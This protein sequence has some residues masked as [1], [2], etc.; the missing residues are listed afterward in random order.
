MNSRFVLVLGLAA[1]VSTT[2]A[3]G[4]ASSQGQGRA[5][6]KAQIRAAGFRVLIGMRRDS[7]S[8]GMISPGQSALNDNA[9]E[10][11][12]QNLERKGLRRLGRVTMVPV[13]YGTVAEADL[14]R[15]MNDPTVEYVEP[16]AFSPLAVYSSGPTVRFAQT[17]P[18]GIPR[19]TAPTAWALGGS[20]AYGAGV[21]VGYLDSGGDSNHPDLLF[22]GGYSIVKGSAASADWLDNIASCKGHG[23]HIAGTIAARNNV[24]GVVGVAPEA[25]LYA[26]QVFQD[27][28]GVCGSYTSSEIAGIDWASKNGIRVVSI[29][30]GGTSFSSSYQSMISSAVSK[31]MYVVAAAG[32]NSSTTLTYPGGYQDVISVGALT[33]SNTK[34]SYSNYGPQLYIAAPGDNIYSTMPGGYGNKSGTSM[35]TPHVAGV[36]T[37]LLARYPGITRAQLLARLE[38]GALDLGVVGRDNNTGWGLARAREAMDAAVSQPL[39]LAVAP[40]SR[41]DTVASGATSADA[42]WSS[43]SLTGDNNATTAWSASA[44]H[45]WTQL[46][47]ASGTGSGTVGWNRNPSGLAAGVHVDTITVVAGSQTVRVIDS[48]VVLPPPTPLALSVSPTSRRDSAEV[49]A[50]VAHA[51]SGTVN[52]SG[53]G[54]STT[55]WTATRKSAWLV[56]TTASGTGS[57][58]VRW[59]RNPTGLLAGVY[60]DTVTV[61]AVGV[62]A[63]SIID[64]LRVYV[65]TRPLSEAVSPHNRYHSAKQSSNT[66]TDSATVV[67]T[68]AGSSLAAWTATSLKPWTTLTV[69]AGV[70]SGNVRWSHNLTGLAAGTYVDTITVVTPNA[71]GSPSSVIDTLVV[72]AQKGKRVGRTTSAGNSIN[73]GAA[74]RI[75]SAYVDVEVGT[76]WAAITS[77]PWVTLVTGNGDGPGY[78]RWQRN[79]DVVSYGISV[80]SIVVLR[81]SVEDGD[82]ELVVTETVMSGADQVPALVAASALFGTAELTALQREMLDLLGNANGRYDV[83]DLLAYLDRTGH[84]L[85]APMMGR[86]MALPRP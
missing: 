49:G 33:S 54:A 58:K 78:L 11:I 46:T 85:S 56:L 61:S 26:I 66:L 42:D 62:S 29:S 69:A 7:L 76:P 75:D 59:T 38:Q 6:L 27:V 70:G 18:W 55:A 43:V 41:R 47:S 9:A 77:A 73:D 8:R 14:D 24:D 80:D 52:L 72:T 44:K 74:P 22:A 60:V 15:L 20:M 17:T 40:A 3:S 79:L 16:D 68:G 35:A 82:V 5:A 4:Q 83:G 10:A 65:D 86:V 51:D 71:L 25:S 30:I 45:A 53:T 48:L 2:P 36:V 34:S 13:V 84:M 32:N 64:S 57:G 23:T 31:G 81:G 12:A 39:V 67:L 63:A 19:V 50:L 21:K 1:L 28:G 37:L